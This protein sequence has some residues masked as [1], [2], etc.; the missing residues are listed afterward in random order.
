MRRILPVFL[1]V[2]ALL[3][4]VGLNV[5]ANTSAQADPVLRV[6]YAGNDNEPMAQGLLLAIQ[7][8]N[9]AGGVEAAD[10]R[11]YTY[12]LVTPQ[13]EVSAPDQIG[14]VYSN[15]RSQG[16]FVIFGPNDN[17]VVQPVVP[18]LSNA[19]VPIIT[20]ATFDALFS[21]D[22]LGNVFRAVAPERY[23]GASMVDF[24]VN[25]LD[26]ETIVVVRQGEEWR[27]AV[28]A[29]RF[30]LNQDF[31][32]TPAVLVEVGTVDDAILRVG[33]ISSVNPDAVMMY[34]STPLDSA[35]FLAALRGADWRGYFVHRDAREQ[36]TREEF[37]PLDTAGVLGMSSWNYG[38][39]EALNSTFVAQYVAEFGEVPGPMT[40]AGYDAMFAINR[41]VRNSGYDAET[42]RTGLAAVTGLDLVRGP[43][44]P[45]TY[46]EN[47]LSTTV[48]IY[49]LTGNGGALTIGIYDNLILRE[50]FVG[51]V[52]PVP[53]GTLT[54]TTTALPSATPSVVTVTV[55]VPR[56][57]VR[58]GPGTEYDIIGQAEEGEQ[59]F[60]AGHNGDF[61]WYLIQFEG[62][63]G[64]VTAEL[65][66]VFDPGNLLPTLPVVEPP[67]TPT[68]GAATPVGGTGPGSDTADIVITGVVYQPPVPQPGCQFTA[69]ATVLNQGGTD[70]GPFS[71]ATT[72]IPNNQ[73][74]YVGAN[75]QN[76]QANT[77]TTVALQQ[78]VNDSVF[79]P[80][81][82]FVADL[83]N[84]VVEGDAGEANNE[85]RTA[86]KVDKPTLQTATTN[87]SAPRDFDFHGGTND[88][89]WSGGT[90]T[91]SNGAQIGL[92]NNLQYENIVYSQVPSVA[93]NP[94]ANDPQGDQVY[95]FITAE[96]Q[97]GVMKI[98][99]RF[100]DTLDFTY[101]VYNDDSTCQ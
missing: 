38:T 56:L 32:I 14:T 62:R 12:E 89:N 88:F 5:S 81:L 21:G 100:G 15:L 68:Q 74:T 61:S 63:V 26:V 87:I 29:L 19:E 30:S 97:R 2:F 11:T 50:A 47:N 58:S 3:I 95:G 101:R 98:N 82:A 6:G 49:E 33:E 24:L 37:D 64:W 71:V 48:Y 69:Q 59:F 8:I 35:T 70:A 93:T 99:S 84:T 22:E 73:A 42:L 1:V 31:G 16:A 92:F 52:A 60:V 76:L 54:P 79:V 7:Q 51:D 90:I 46:E 83:N 13:I 43:I 65:V 85:Y 72:F 55:D 86:F 41:V 40:V 20:G 67:A 75:V 94:S 39:D 27:D 96:G 23:Y 57:N 28:T 80:T 77:T 10:G 66:E 17:D 91:M 4:G 78:T 25:V 44:D 45:A 53:T 36:L 34:G 9:E 18:I